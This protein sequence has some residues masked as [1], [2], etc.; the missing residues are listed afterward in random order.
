MSQAVDAL[1]A[2]KRSSAK[3]RQAVADQ[4]GKANATVGRSWGALGQ[5]EEA[6]SAGSKSLHSLAERLGSKVND[7][8]E[9]TEAGL[10]G[11]RVSVGDQTARMQRTARVLM[12][13]MILA[14]LGT[15]AVITLVLLRGGIG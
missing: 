12:V 6:L 10:R 4:L 15:G 9:Q 7:L 8:Q 13:L 11:V 1:E 2:A 3:E 14:V 5:A